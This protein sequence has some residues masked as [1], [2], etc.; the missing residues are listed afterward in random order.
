MTETAAQKKGL[1]GMTQPLLVEQALQLSIP[2]LDTFFLSRVSDASAAAAGAMTPVMYFCINILWVTV[3]AGSSV[4]SQRLGAGNAARAASTVA[5]YS[6]WSVLL[7]SILALAVYF[8]APVITQL[9]GLPEQVRTEANIYMSIMCLMLVVWSGKSVVQSILNIYGQPKWN[10]Y[11][12]ILFFCSNVLGNAIVV[13]GLFGFPKLG[14]VGVAWASVLAS[15]LAVVF[16]AIVI[17]FLIKLEVQWQHFIKEFRSAST[18]TFKIA[19]PGMIEP[20][21]FDFNMMVLNGFAA[22]LGTVALAAK[23]YTFNTFLLGLIITIA[24]ATATQVL[25]SQYVGF[26][27]YVKASEQM[28]KSLKAALWGAGVVMV[29]LVAASHP[30]MSI[31]SDND[32]LLGSAFWLFLL[33]ALSEP[34]RVVNI[35]VGFSLRATGDGFLISVIGPLFTWLVA[36]PIAYLCAFVL[37]WGIYGILFS[38]IL[39][40]SCRSIMYWMRWRTN[41]W[42]HTHVHARE[43]AKLNK[44]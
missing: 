44:G 4:A 18:N 39:D 41:R 26:G 2:V 7:G 22:S 43:Q 34:G 12:N 28:R 24:I 15:V 20:L 36:I 1:W 30:I 38:A 16:S 33:A 13:F 11:A 10:M 42:Q 25:I 6:C 5:T 19:L 9:M 29:I 3:F 14:I 27:N 23:V 35:I 37:G 21:S 8:L 32:I 40:E 17:F 31:Y